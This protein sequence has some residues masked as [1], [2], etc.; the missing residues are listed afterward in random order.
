[1]KTSINL[2]NVKKLD[3]FPSL[4]VNDDGVIALFVNAD[5]KK[6]LLVLGL[7]LLLGLLLGLQKIIMW[8]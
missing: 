5:E 3:T 7:T 2:D 4:W 1:M 8:I 6:T